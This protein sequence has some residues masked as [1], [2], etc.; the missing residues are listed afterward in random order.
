MTSQSVQASERFGKHNLD[1]IPFSH[2]G[3]GGRF[4]KRDVVS[5]LG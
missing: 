3:G 4:G 2:S 5:K 1:G